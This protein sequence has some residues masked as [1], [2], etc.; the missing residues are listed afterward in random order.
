MSQSNKLLLEDQLCFALYAATNA[1]VRT[2]RPMLAN[3]GLT[4]PQYLVM[5]VLWQGGTSTVNEIADRLCL[6]PSAISPL[7]DRLEQAGFATRRRDPS[8]RRTVLVDLTPE[9]AQ[10]EAGAARA[11]ATVVCRTQMQPS[12]FSNLRDNLHQL[13]VQLNEDAEQSSGANCAS[14]LAG[15]GA[16]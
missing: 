2:Y 8:D 13:L 7:I 5:I 15:S 12:E 3:L 11:Q 16:G 9:G 1:I 14:A 10:L 4:Y 6:P